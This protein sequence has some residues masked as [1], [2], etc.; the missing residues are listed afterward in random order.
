MAPPIS[1][2][3]SRC[4]IGEVLLFDLRHLCRL[5]FSLLELTFVGPFQN[6]CNFTQLSL[7]GA[8]GDP[9]LAKDFLSRQII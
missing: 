2:Q 1:S 7:Y 6:I 8:H 4:F 5:T 9:L 3:S